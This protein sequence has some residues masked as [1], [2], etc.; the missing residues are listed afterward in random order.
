MRSV[1]VLKS[2]LRF[3]QIHHVSNVKTVNGTAVTQNI[4]NRFVTS[5]PEPWC[6]QSKK[7][8]AK[9]VAIAVGGRYTMVTTASVF[10]ALASRLAAS[11]RALESAAKAVEL[12]ARRM[13]CNV[14]CWVMR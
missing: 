5:N 2:S 7:G 8:I 1:T 12:S 4:Q 14:S 9:M 3:I 11:A 10:I 6:S 13:D